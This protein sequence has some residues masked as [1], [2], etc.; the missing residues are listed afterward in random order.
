M[1][2]PFYLRKT[3]LETTPHALHQILASILSNNQQLFAKY[4]WLALNS[5][6]II[7]LTFLVNVPPDSAIPFI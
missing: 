3:G 7:L 1:M 2:H 5:H 4:L 6:N